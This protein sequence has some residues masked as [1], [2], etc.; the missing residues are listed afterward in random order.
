LAPF[1]VLG[2]LFVAMGVVWLSGFALVASR[3]SS[4][5]RQPAVKRMLDRPTG[6]VLIGLGLRLATEHR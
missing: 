3:A 5:L 4:A 6:I 2:G 1:L